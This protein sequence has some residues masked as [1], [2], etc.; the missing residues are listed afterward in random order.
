VSSKSVVSK[1]RKLCVVCAT[2]FE[3]GNLLL[4]RRGRESLEAFTTTGWG[5]C[6]QDEALRADGYVALIECDPQR[7]GPVSDGGTLEQEQAYRTGR[8]AHVK[9]HVFDALL[10]PSTDDLV[11]CFVET[12]VL[13]HVAWV[14]T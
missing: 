13:D 10:A 1:E 11:F 12:G 14:T 7:S 9:R 3:T 8:L 6:P 2:P 4:D 5:L